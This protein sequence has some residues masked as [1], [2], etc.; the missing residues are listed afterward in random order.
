M[1]SLISGNAQ[2]SKSICRL[3][4]FFMLASTLAD[5]AKAYDITNRWTATKT[6]GGGLQRGDAITVTWSV[7]P[8]GES[9]SRGGPSDLVDYLDVGWNVNVADRTPDLTNR[10]WWSWMDRVYDQYQRVSGLTMIYDAE[11]DAAGVDTGTSGDIRI[12]GVPFT[13]EN[14]KGGVLADNSFPNNGDMRIDTYRGN[15]GIPSF[16]HTNAAAFRNLIA[17]ESGHGMGLSHSDISGANAVM[18]TPLES[19][20][21]GLQF[22]DI[23]AFNR[24]YGDPLEKLGGN[25][26]SGTAYD[27]TPMLTNSQV[28]LGTDANDS[29]ADETDS[30]WVGIDGTSDQDWFQIDMATTG[31]LMVELTPLGPTYSTDEQGA[32]TDFSA[33]SDLSFEIYGPGRNSIELLNT[34][35]ATEAGQVEEFSQ[36]IAEAGSYYIRVTGEA[37]LNQFYQL[38]A[39]TSLLNGINGD[40]NQDGLVNQL[41]IDA[42][43]LGWQSD[44]TALDD[45]GKYNSG[46][47]DF[48]GLTDLTDAYLLQQAFIGTGQSVSFASILSI[49]VPEPNAAL[50]LIAGVSLLGLRRNY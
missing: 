13:W 11:Q 36:V 38:E 12:G 40:V 44:T 49:A 2:I 6:D 22:D 1:C 18:E 15:D 34:V 24:L 27:L 48:S 33:R 23:Y 7:V 16:W 31:L 14:D 43:V 10:P 3:M 20:F 26:T 21:W 4:V 41:D 30:D 8:D 25:D 45:L 42:F 17:H 32:N 37:D 47:I 9:W 5:S 46:D 28:I 35:D 39:S 19:N 29:S 50:L